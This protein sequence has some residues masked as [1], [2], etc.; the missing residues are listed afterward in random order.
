MS[1]DEVK[2]TKI[3]SHQMVYDFTNHLSELHKMWLCL[4]LINIVQ[5]INSFW[6][7]VKATKWFKE[8]ENTFVFNKRYV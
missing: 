3:K 7:V 4:Q 1:L 5:S 8:L 6:F 2:L